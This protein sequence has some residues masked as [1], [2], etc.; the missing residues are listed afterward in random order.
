MAT[1]DISIQ[2]QRL[3]SN[4]GGW[5]ENRST[6]A[7]TLPH[8]SITY[9]HKTIALDEP[10]KRR[11]VVRSVVQ[12]DGRRNSLT[13][14]VTEQP[15]LYGT[16]IERRGWSIRAWVAPAFDSPPWIVQGLSALVRFVLS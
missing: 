2:R 15:K 1:I 5:L 12:L 9:I 13:V 3:Q 7:N 10:Q 6:P 8:S 16:E 4:I 14:A 11:D